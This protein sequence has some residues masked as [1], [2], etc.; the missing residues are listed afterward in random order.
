MKLFD[1]VKKQSVSDDIG[2][3]DEDASSPIGQ[4]MSVNEA[5]CKKQ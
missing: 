1:R 4:A 5:A 3:A 2:D